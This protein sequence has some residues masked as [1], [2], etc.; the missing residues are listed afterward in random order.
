MGEDM[1]DTS[2]FGASLL[3]KLPEVFTPK[4]VEVASKG[5]ITARMLNDWRREKRGP[6]FIRVAGGKKIIYT[7][8]AFAKTL[9]PES[10]AA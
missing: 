2:E 1:S 7:R 5:V 9:S 3:A 8:E 6:A 10:N 4:M